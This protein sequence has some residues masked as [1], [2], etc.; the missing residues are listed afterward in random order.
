MVRRFVGE[1]AGNE[2]QMWYIDGTKH[3]DVVIVKS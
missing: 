3:Y 2:V 1:R